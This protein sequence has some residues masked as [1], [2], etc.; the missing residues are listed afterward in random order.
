MERQAQPPRRRPALSI[1][2]ARHVIRETKLPPAFD[3]QELAR[4]LYECDRSYRV[5]APM[6]P[7][8]K[9]RRVFAEEVGK[10]AKKLRD[11]LED[12][13]ADF[14]LPSPG[15]V[16]RVLLD[17]MWQNCGALAEV[18][19]KGED[20][21]RHDQERRRP[22]LGVRHDPTWVLIGGKLWTIFEVLYGP[23]KKG[24]ARKPARDR[25]IVAACEALGVKKPTSS[26]IKT[27]RRR[28][29]KQPPEAWMDVLFSKMRFRQVQA[30]H[31]REHREWRRKHPKAPLTQDEQIREARALL[32]QQHAAM[33]FMLP[34]GLS[35]RDA[36]KV[37]VNPGRVLHAAHLPIPAESGQRIFLPPE[38]AAEWHRRGVVTYVTYES[39]PDPSSS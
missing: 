14:S 18:V 35:A 2:A 26:T 28:V 11:L 30:I 33:G 21:W 15:Q 12:P 32:R 34:P 16:N 5:R 10:A 8:A 39:E 23:G 3:P 31:E 7:S 9:Q 29:L 36:V 20:T 19:R 25:F 17:A 27:Y 1:E 24:D 38:A 37:T 6:D 22:P 13:L 4:Y